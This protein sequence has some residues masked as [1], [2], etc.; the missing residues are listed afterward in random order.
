[1]KKA[2]GIQSDRHGITPERDQVLTGGAQLLSQPLQGLENLP[3]PVSP[4]RDTH[5]RGQVTMV[6]ATLISAT[7]QAQ[8]HGYQGQGHHGYMQ[9]R[10]NS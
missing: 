1:M 9:V 7:L 2:V 3:A 10:P 5:D 6:R 8:G 4:P